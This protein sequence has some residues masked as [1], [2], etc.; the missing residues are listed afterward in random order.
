MI[1]EIETWAQDVRGSVFISDE[2][3]AL[4]AAWAAG[5]AVIAV[6][7]GE[8]GRFM[9]LPFPYVVPRWEDVTEEVAGL[10]LCRKLNLPWEI[11]KTRR[12]VI[13]EL[14]L[15]DGNRIPLEEDLRDEELLFRDPEWLK[16]YIQ[17]QYPFYEYGTWALCLKSGGLLAGLG[18]VSLPRLSP[19]LSQALDPAREYLELGYRIFQPYRGRGLGLEACLGIKDYVQ[20]V[21]GCSLCAL[22]EEKNQASRR[23]AESLGMKAAASESIQTDSGSWQ[24]RLLYVQT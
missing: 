1:R 6:E 11:A 24:R 9:G 18:G 8:E 10:V 7:D 12:L 17:G 22:I 21:F 4:L 14:V 15:E 2:K 20:D 5:R 13:R 16:P 3:E 23:I 19:E